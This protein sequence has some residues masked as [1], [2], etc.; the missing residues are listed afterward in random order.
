MASQPSKTADELTTA[1]R[2]LVDKALE[3]QTREQ[4]AARGREVA[5]AI[6][7]TAGTAAER[8]SEMANDVWRD[9]APQRRDAMK[10]AERMRRD[11]FKWGR[12]AWLKQ[13]QPALRNAW[14]RRAAAI[15]AA[16][17]AVPASRELVDQARIR[18]G[19]RQREEHRWRIF[20][21]GL[22]LGAIGGAIAAL[23]T[24]PRP[25]REVRDELAS[26]ARDAA[27]NAGEWVPIFQREAI[28]TPPISQ[29]RTGEPSSPASASATPSGAERA[30]RRARP[31][32]R[33]VESE[34]MTPSTSK[35]NGADAL[36]SPA[37]PEIDQTENDA[38]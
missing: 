4:I 7:E 3:S 29:S 38:I 35:G 11:A 27:T 12:K 32:K 37:K 5:A 25:G 1:I 14:S 30:E 16:G 17:L 8:A 26:R 36:S 2:S 9:S 13:L 15:G 20:F 23:L 18:L 24:A 22:V 10:S 28:E 34:E 31:R 21:L 6:A 33:A 19:L